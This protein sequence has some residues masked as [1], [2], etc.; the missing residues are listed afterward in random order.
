[1]H[2]VIRSLTCENATVEVSIFEKKIMEMFRE[3]TVD[4][5]GEWLRLN[6]FSDKVIQ[7]FQG[8]QAS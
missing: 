6:N 8:K 7:T 2:G 1:M 5:L 3:K 4:E